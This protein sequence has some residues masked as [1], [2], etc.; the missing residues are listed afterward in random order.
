MLFAALHGLLYAWALPPWD[1]FDEEQH[2]SY[3][4]TLREERRIPHLDDLIQPEIV[5]SAAAT[6]RWTAFR[7]GR[8]ESLEPAEMGLEG[9][10]Y[11]A[12]Q[13]PLYYLLVA[14][15]NPLGRGDIIRQLELARALGALLLAALAWVTW[16]LAR[17]WFPGA[18][19][20]CWA[21]AALLATGLPAMAEAGGRV[22]NDLLVALLVSAALLAAVDLLRAPTART[23]LILGLLAAGAVLTK[24]TGLL[25]LLLAVAAVVVLAYR[26]QLTIALAT[27]ALAPGLAVAALWALFTQR[28]Y[29]VWSGSDAFLEIVTPFPPAGPADFLERLWLNAWSSYWGAYDAG[30]WKL[31]A[32]VLLAV[33]VIGGLIGLWGRPETLPALA[34]TGLLCA[35]LVAGLWSAY[36]DGL[37]APHGRMLLP[38]VPAVAAL[39]AG[40]LAGRFGMRALGLAVAAVLGISAGFFVGWFYPF[41]HGGF[42]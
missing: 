7:I 4:L 23:A 40:G 34:L 36:D 16:S 28:R 22:N 38:A 1:L 2:F 29:G 18:G 21:G 24:S 33:V 41:F 13:P 39:V 32:G 6:D 20:R 35:G 3:A 25:A 11:E 31:A 15:A 26:K 19:P 30:V 14:A 27:R 9:R 12:Y 42:A 8:P 5:S 10:S 17:R 37:T